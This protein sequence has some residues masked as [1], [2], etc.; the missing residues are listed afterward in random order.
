MPDFHR[1]QRESFVRHRRGQDR[2]RW[3]SFPREPDGCRQPIEDVAQIQRRRGQDR[4][5]GSPATG[6][7]RDLRHLRATRADDDGDERCLQWRISGRHRADRV[8]HAEGKDPRQEWQRGRN[9]TPK[10]ARIG[11]SRWVDF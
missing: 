7:D 1:R 5:Q 9:A 8:G 10:F 4:G 11:V 3:V 2:A 6:R